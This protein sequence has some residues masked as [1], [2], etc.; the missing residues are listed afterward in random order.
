M[1]G[2]DKMN[3]N[4]LIGL[5]FTYVDDA[6][7]ESEW[8]TAGRIGKKMIQKELNCDLWIASRMLQVLANKNQWFPHVSKMPE[9]L[10][11]N[12]VELF[13]KQLDRMGIRYITT[14]HGYGGI[15]IQPIR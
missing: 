11:V 8:I 7:S 4:K 10:P 9:T 14:N 6:S 5:A 12:A 13:E 1:R 3:M 15:T 2:S